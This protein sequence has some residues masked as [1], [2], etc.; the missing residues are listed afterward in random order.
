M[1]RTIYALL[2]GIDAYPAPI[3]A[4]SGCVNDIESFAAS[5]QE[6]VNQDKGVTLRLKTLKNAEATRKTVIDSFR[7]HFGL[8]KTGDVVLF[9]YSGHGSQEP[10]PA[11]FWAIEPDHLDET[12]VCYDSRSPGGWH[13]AD[14]EIAKLIGEVAAN[15]PHVAAILDCCHS[16]SGTRDAEVVRRIE[17]DQRRRPIESFILSPEEVQA[18]LTRSGGQSNRSWNISNEGRHILL[19]A[20]ASDQEA[21]EFTG[22]GQRRGAFSFFLGEALKSANGVPTYRDLFARIAALVST[23]VRNQSPQFEASHSVDLD[24]VFLDGAIQPA[25]PT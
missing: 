6:R 12:L 13:L 21:K 2:V 8:A 5:L 15:G 19:A 9:Y 3:P 10:S 22:N 18:T 23:Q 16:G 7:V 17:T 25:P 24:A 14:K 1:S 11:E 4:L 20:C